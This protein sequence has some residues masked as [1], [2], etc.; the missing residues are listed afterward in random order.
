MRD[1]VNKELINIKV[2]P[3]KNKNNKK[4]YKSAHENETERSLH[5]EIWNDVH[6]GREI[7]ST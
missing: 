4:N 6:G 7:L 1:K 5:A 3:K 2:S